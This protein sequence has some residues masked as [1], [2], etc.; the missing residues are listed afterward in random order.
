M[1]GLEGVHHGR[2]CRLLVAMEY[3]RVH[4]YDDVSRSGGPKEVPGGGGGG[5][6]V[7]LAY[8][9]HTRGR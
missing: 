6:K 1:W 9:I 8:P 7:L 5:H 2:G 4:V 3:Y